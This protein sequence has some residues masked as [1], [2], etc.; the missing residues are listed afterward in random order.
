M[1]SYS[2]RG[3]GPTKENPYMPSI[4]MWIVEVITQVLDSIELFPSLGSMNRRMLNK[5][6]FCILIFF[7]NL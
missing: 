3:S 2:I 4:R 1:K 6:E 5:S 7:C